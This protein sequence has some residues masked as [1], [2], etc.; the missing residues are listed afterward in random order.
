MTTSRG[1]RCKDRAARP[2]PDRPKEETTMDYARLG[3]TGLKVSRICLGCMTYGDPDRPAPDGSRRW[4]WALPDDHAP[5]FFKRALQP[6]ITSLKTPNA[7][8]LCP[9]DPAV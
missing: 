9:R 6:D 7:H 2:V 1:G 3:T 4:P 8:S 5:P